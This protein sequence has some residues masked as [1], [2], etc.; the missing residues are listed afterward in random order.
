MPD[1]SKD[2]NKKRGWWK[3][4]TLTAKVLIVFFAIVALGVISGVGYVVSLP[5]YTDLNVTYGNASGETSNIVVISGVTESGANITVNNHSVTPDSVG[6]FSYKITN[7]PL[8]TQNVT[9]VAK[10]S[11]KEP[12]TAIIEINRIEENG[13]YTLEVQLL[14]QTNVEILGQFS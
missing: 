7:I 10:V 14:N 2:G 3:R 1:S 6:K 8:G 13:G 9:V 5:T 4:Q 11:D 12:T